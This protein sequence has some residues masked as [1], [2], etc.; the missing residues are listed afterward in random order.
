MRVSRFAVE[1]WRERVFRPTYLYGTT[2]NGGS[3]E[4]GTVFKISTN[5][6]FGSVYSFSS[7]FG[8]YLQKSA[9]IQASDS[10]LYGTTSGG[11]SNS[12]GTV[13]KI[14]TTGVFT[15][16]HSFT[17][18]DD[19]S[20]PEG[21]LVQ[22]ANGYLYGTTE[23]G[24]FSGLGTVFQI[25]ADGTFTTL[26]S[27]SGGS[28]GGEPT[29]SLVVFDGFL[30]GTTQVGGATGGGDV[31]QILIPSS[32]VSPVIIGPPLLAGDNIVFSFPTALS[33]SYTVQQSTNLASTNWNF[34]TN[35]PGNGQPVQLAIPT[36]SPHAAF[37]RVIGQ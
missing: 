32:G 33:Q 29:G 11:G 21:S 9:L 34:Y 8:Y 27:F 23:F 2:Q 30:C 22:A 14:S 37:F 28:D 36:A 31:F 26:Y 6:V 24:G 20:N 18:A 16:L 15:L 7:E 19:G 35:I 5:R 10:Y 3:N 17:G 1:Y 25:G 12:D 13:Y 4:V